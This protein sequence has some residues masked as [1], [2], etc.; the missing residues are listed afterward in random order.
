MSTPHRRRLVLVL[1]FVLA[2]TPAVAMGQPWARW[3][4]PDS[5]L[6]GVLE[7]GRNDPNGFE[8]AWNALFVADLR[9][10]IAKADSAA[11]LHALAKRVADTEPSVFETHIGRD[12]LALGSRWTP[13]Q[14]RERIAAAVEESLAVVARNAGDIAT[15][16]SL[17]RVAIALHQK[18]RER[19]REAVLWGTLGATLLR[20]GDDEHALEV[21]GHAL[22]TRRALGDRRLVGNTLNDLGQ[23]MNRL[24]RYPE[25][26]GYLLEA[27]AVRERGQRWADLA[28]TVGALGTTLDG[29]GKPDS[30]RTCFLRAIDLSA[31]LADSARLGPTL[32]NY[33]LF[34][35]GRGEDA[36]ALRVTARARD[37]AVAKN[38]VARLANI[39]LNLGDLHSRLGHFS[40]SL[41]HYQTS[42]RLSE[43][44][45][46]ATAEALCG[47]GRALRAMGDFERAHP[48]LDRAL[49]I[50]DSLEDPQL[51][52]IV[53]V[54]LADVAGDAGDATGA[55][56]TGRLA[57]DRAMA[58]GDSSLVRFAANALGNVAFA[59]RRYAGAAD[60]F[61]RALRA[62][63]NAPLEARATLRLNRAAMWQLMG[64]L[65]E[66]ESE[67]HEVLAL[68]EQAGAYETEL[69][70]LTDL[71]DLAQRRRDYPTAFARYGRAVA[72]I[73]TLRLRQRS[74]RDAVKAVGA[75]SDVYEAIVHLCATLDAVYPDSGFA[76]RGF[77][78][79]ERSRARVFLD[80]VAAA[81]T[82][83]EPIATVDLDQA[84]RLQDSNR[85]ALLEYSVGDSSSSL[86]IVRRDRS[87]HVLLPARAALKARVQALR[88]GLADPT[89]ADSRT[90]RDASRELYRM[91]VAP[92]EPYLNGVD[93]LVVSADGPL[94]FVPFEALLARD[95]PEDRVPK[96]AYLVERYR[97]SYTPSAT[98]LALL[99]R[100]DPATASRSGGT[101]TPAAIVAVGNPTF[102]DVPVPGTGPLTPLPNTAAELAMFQ[103]HSKGRQ[104]VVL[105]GTDA[106]RARVLELPALSRAE[107]VHFATHGYVDAAEPERSGLWLAP[108]SAD[109]PPSRIEVSDI[110]S[111]RLQADLVTLSACETGLGRLERG[112]GVV[113]LSR[114]FLAAGARSV[115]VSL[116]NVNDRS[117]AQ[118]MSIL[119]ARL[120]NRRRLDDAL[121]DAKRALLESPETRSPFYWAPFVLVGASGPIP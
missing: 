74:D 66:A 89:S 115:V 40:E 61:D 29:L 45:T 11:R 69:E 101:S 63:P 107:I 23:T 53:L 34:L 32:I 91:L 114:G 109:E 46:R 95:V 18:L 20:A 75:R 7:A 49:A 103:Q 28:N 98:V 110:M 57:L 56:R 37:I 73:D 67:Y 42:M 55:E 111:L 87:A 54:N 100:R 31:S 62:E 86:W 65:D 82:T 79:A 77:A 22:A 39:E 36:E 96:G 81:G 83:T 50:A 85:E 90:T 30:A 120:A 104:I 35:M 72:M 117:T 5:A 97:I 52:A 105:S 58:A 9:A 80:L 24:D 2:M 4:V 76:E 16:D 59:G 1:P 8:S 93:H 84:R 78:W 92:A 108:A 113:G 21:Y 12:A 26:Y 106:T 60:W 38:D 6:F 19:R 15:A 10:A 27:A 13:R 88:R 70:A 71:G 121:T 33:G 118:L 94:A 43:G 64:R 14:R 119:Y 99:E 44:D 48:L 17:F 47:T 3:S 68:A 51:Q 116:W 25:A 41:V 112:E 102:G